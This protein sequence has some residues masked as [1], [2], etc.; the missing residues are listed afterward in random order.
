VSDLRGKVALVTGGSSGIGA[1]AAR[2]F[3]RA[4]ARVVLAARGVER[5]EA[6]ARELR[7]EGADTRFIRADMARPADV[8]RLIAETVAGLQQ[9][10]HHR[11][12]RGAGSPAP[13]R[14]SGGGGRGLALLGRVLVRHRA[15]VDRGWRND[16]RHPLA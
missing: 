8:E 5:G 15:L 2:A 7:E 3:A 12:I 11:P 10:G 4:G 9:R 14:P 1:A 16:R 6:V 13:D